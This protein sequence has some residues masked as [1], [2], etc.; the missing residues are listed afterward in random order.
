MKRINLKNVVGKRVIVL[1]FS[2]VLVGLIIL[3]GCGG[4]SVTQEV[5]ANLS[6]VRYNLFEVKNET[7]RANAMSG[8]REEPYAYDGISG[9]KVEFCVLTVFL[10]NDTHDFDTLDFV[11]TINEQPIEATLERNPRNNSLM[12]DICKVLED[13]DKLSLKIDGIDGDFEMPC[14]SQSWAVQ[15]DEVIEIGL[16]TLGEEINQFFV[17]KNFAAEVYVKII[18][19][20]KGEF[21]QYFWYFGVLG[22][23]KT[24][25]CVLIDL[26]GNVVNK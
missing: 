4:G 24:N 5:R 23:N 1:A 2:V 15:Y 26:N 9:K 19:D 25:L 18:Y 10:T 8:L 6:D 3:S 22:E 21:E 12:A 20:E 17:K 16:T 13:D 11:I 14:V 7:L